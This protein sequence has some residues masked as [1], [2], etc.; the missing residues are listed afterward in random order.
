MTRAGRPWWHAEAACTAPCNIPASPASS[1]G[2]RPS[3][4]PAIER[5]RARARSR[6]HPHGYRRGLGL[7]PARRPARLLECVEA[8]GDPAVVEAQELVPRARPRPGLA[9]LEQPALG[10]SE[11]PAPPQC[12]RTPSADS[13]AATRMGG[14][15]RAPPPRPKPQPCSQPTRTA[16]C[17]RTATR[18]G[19]PTG[20][21][22]SA[23]RVS[24]ASGEPLY[25][26]G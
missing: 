21:Q 23:G 14:S 1:P 2:H 19:W 7:R 10:H 12:R 16:Y 26:F 9:P 18:A 3:S 20:R 13:C 25:L 15:G 6:S 17:P 8:H 11:A 4:I 22:R 24:L 5:R